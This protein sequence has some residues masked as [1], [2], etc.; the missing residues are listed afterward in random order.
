MLKIKNLSKSFGHKKAL[1]SISFDLQ[2]GRITG[3]LGPNGAGKTTTIKILLGLIKKDEGTVEIN[4]K[5]IE[6]L[7]ELKFIIKIGSLMEF[8]SFYSH[9]TAKE[10]LEILSLLDGYKIDEKRLDTLLTL[11]GLEKEKDK[12][13]E[14]F[15]FGM[16]QKLAL[17][18]ALL[19]EPELL[20]LDEPFNGLDPKAMNDLNQLLK[21]FAA[22]NGT[23]FISS[24]I[25][26]EVENLCDRLVIINHGQIILERELEFLKG[27]NL[28]E[29]YLKLTSNEKS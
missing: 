10:N 18:N 23:V 22:N 5:E 21:E 8:P 13:V 3:F 11:V 20:I 29:I 7:E 28:K 15:S 24:H 6:N 19:N 14:T 26:S 1:E 4:G 12:R 25:L 2:K 9:L 27:S 16:K 17:A